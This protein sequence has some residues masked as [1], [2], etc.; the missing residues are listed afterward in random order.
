MMLVGSRVKKKGDDILLLLVV[1]DVSTADSIFKFLRAISS[2]SLV[3]SSTAVSSS[4]ISSSSSINFAH[5]SERD[6]Y[7]SGHPFHFLYEVHFHNDRICL[8]TRSDFHPLHQPLT[9]F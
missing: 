7:H 2:A 9:F 6:L 8:D 3:P 5:T 4:I 1:L